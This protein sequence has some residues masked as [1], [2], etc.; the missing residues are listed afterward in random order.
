ITKSAYV[1][2]FDR[3]TGEP[4]FPIEDMPAPPS[5][6]E[7]EQAAA[8]QPVPVKPPPFSRHK[9]GFTD[10][11]DVTPESREFVMK[12][13]DVLR[14]GHPFHPPSREGTLIFPGFDGGGEWGGAAADPESGIL[15]VSASEMPW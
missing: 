1:F 8:T 9:F 2:L 6:L 10:I 7:G 13:W 3:E 4:L 5:D 11:T 15:Y 14:K 12:R